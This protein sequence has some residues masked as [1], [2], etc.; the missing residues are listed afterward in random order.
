MLFTDGF[1]R[2]A[3]R[4][5]IA[6]AGEDGFGTE[7][8]NDDRLAAKVARSGADGVVVGGHLGNAAELLKVMRARLGP[9]TA[10]M[11]G[12]GFL[13]ILDAVKGARPRSRGVVLGRGGRPAERTR[14]PVA[15]RRVIRALGAT[16]ENAYS[17]QA[18]AAAEVVMEAIAR[19]DGTRASVLK[20]LRA[21]KMKDSILGAF[22]FDRYGDMTPAKLT[23][24]R[25]GRSTRPGESLSDD[26]RGAVLDRVVDVPTS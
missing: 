22:G 11:T 12:D 7:D 4:L 9:R 14:S 6:I 15:G 20:E 5:G 3:P 24:M 16:A 8:R 1:R 25:I 21:I 13:P 18:A 2:A 17:M 23:I 26:Y 10:I 19:S